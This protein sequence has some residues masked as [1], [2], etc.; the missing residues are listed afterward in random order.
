MLGLGTRCATGYAVTVSTRPSSRPKGRITPWLSKLGIAFLTWA[1]VAAVPTCHCEPPA[2]ERANAHGCCPEAPSDKSK[3]PLSASADCCVD[4][5]LPTQVEA[6][7]GPPVVYAEIAPPE[8]ETIWP[9]PL[10]PGPAPFVSSVIVP[11]RVAPP[12]L[13]V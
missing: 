7:E 2:S 8:A 13:R 10:E 5:V 11:P 6:R 1:L 9:I 4:A 12:I 3:A